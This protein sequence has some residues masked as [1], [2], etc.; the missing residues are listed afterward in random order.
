MSGQTQIKLH[1]QRIMNHKYV[2]NTWIQA[3]EQVWSACARQTYLIQLSKRT[4]LRPSNTSQNKKKC[5][6]LFDRMFDGL[7]ILS[8][9]TK[10]HQIRWP[11]GKMF[12]NQ[13]LM[14]SINQISELRKSSSLTTVIG[15]AL[16]GSAFSSTSKG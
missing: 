16:S 8:N 2:N 9:T 1:K 13:I 15:T 4:K 11:N 14:T 12:G 10:Q 5:F 3:A 6:K 7:Q